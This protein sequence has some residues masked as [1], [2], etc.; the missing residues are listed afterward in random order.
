MDYM[1][2]QSHLAKIAEMIILKGIMSIFG[3][4]LIPEQQQTDG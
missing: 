4:G 3:D 1:G 2:E